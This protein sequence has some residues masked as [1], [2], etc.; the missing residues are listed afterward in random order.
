M[1]SLNAN[2]KQIICYKCSSPNQLLVE[3]KIDKNTNKIIEKNFVCAK[4]A[5]L[6]Q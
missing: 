1:K 6:F 4:C 3:E 5:N 2:Q